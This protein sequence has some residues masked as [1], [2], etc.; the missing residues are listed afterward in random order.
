M[1]DQL[2][3][4]YDLRLYYRTDLFAHCCECDI[5]HPGLLEPLC[6][7]HAIEWHWNI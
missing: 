7:I 5:N 4:A 3:I 1:I 6:K 2:F